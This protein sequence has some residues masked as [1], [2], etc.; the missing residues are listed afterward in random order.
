MSIAM[1][2]NVSTLARYV[3]LGMLTYKIYGIVA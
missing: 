2:A 3:A 1:G